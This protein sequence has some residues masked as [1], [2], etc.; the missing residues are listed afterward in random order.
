MR[1]WFFQ[2]L[3]MNTIFSWTVLKFVLEHDVLFNCSTSKTF[4][5]LNIICSWTSLTFVLDYFRVSWILCVL[6]LLLHL[7]LIIS[8]FSWILCVLELLLHLFLMISKTSLEHNVFLN[9]SYICSWLFRRQSMNI[10]KYV[11]ELF[12]NVFLIISKTYLE[13]NVS[14]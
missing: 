3:F 8:D 10:I 14:I 2:W 13:Y 7:S 6:E 5:F 1:S 11:L 9:C 4:L 12:L